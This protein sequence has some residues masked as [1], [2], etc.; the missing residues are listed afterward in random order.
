MEEKESIRETYSAIEEPEENNHSTCDLYTSISTLPQ[1][2]LIV[3]CL[4]V[5]ARS[6]FMFYFYYITAPQLISIGEKTKTLFT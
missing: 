2:C 6:R 3:L 5:C 4:F 1:I